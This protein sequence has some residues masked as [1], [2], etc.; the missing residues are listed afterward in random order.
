M[1]V[2][3]RIGIIA[4]VAT[5]AFLVTG[6]VFAIVQNDASENIIILCPTCH[7][8]FDNAKISKRV[9]MYKKLIQNYP[10]QDFT[11]PLFLNT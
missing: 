9:L 3:F 4:A 2:R 7:K 5:M 6:G 8:K 10:D 11:K 1:T